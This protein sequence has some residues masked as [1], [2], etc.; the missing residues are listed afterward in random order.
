MPIKKPFL[1]FLLGLCYGLIATPLIAG[2]LPLQLIK[3]PSGFKIEIYAQ[4]VPNAREMTLSPEGT[5]FV[6]TRTAGKVFA[7]IDAN[8]DYKVDQVYQVAEGL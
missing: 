5:V 4:D 8:K 2:P 3:L 6:G 7:L 1:I